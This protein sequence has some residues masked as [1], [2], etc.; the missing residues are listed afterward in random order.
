MRSF[1]LREI[2]MR[3]RRGVSSTVLAATPPTR[4]LST[5]WSS[6]I[7][8]FLE[9]LSSAGSQSFAF[10]RRAALGKLLAT[11]VM[12]TASKRS[13]KLTA[14]KSYPLPEFAIGDLIAS[15]WKGELG[16]DIVDFGEIL[17][18]RYLPEAQSVFPAN[19]WVY[20]IYWTHST[21]GCESAYPCYDGDPSAASELRRIS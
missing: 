1:E 17:G 8:S 14:L 5:F 16:E 18:V 6:T 7:M 10:S 9:R 13:P 21:C 12:T 4:N 19:T 15:D 2:D 20:Y 3:G 11:A